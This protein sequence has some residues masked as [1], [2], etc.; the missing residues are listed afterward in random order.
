VTSPRRILTLCLKKADV[1]VA[2]AIWSGVGVALIG[3]I[4][5]VYFRE[6][7]TLL[8]VIGTLAIIGGVIALNVAS[9]R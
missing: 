2:Y 4:G 3:A 8:K 7:I 1:S 9:G 5:V 6:P